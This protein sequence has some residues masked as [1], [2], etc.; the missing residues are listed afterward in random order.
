MQNEIKKAYRVLLLSAAQLPP[1][2]PPP[3]DEML[4]HHKV[5]H[6]RTNPGTQLY[7]W[8]NGDNLWLKERKVKT[9][10][11]LLPRFPD[12][13]SNGQL[14]VSNLQI[15]I[16]MSL[17]RTGGGS[18]AAYSGNEFCQHFSSCGSRSTITDSLLRESYLFLRIAQ[19]YHHL[20]THSF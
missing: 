9:R 17:V 1:P 4:A 13:K 14:L 3:L 15:T 11:G 12:M 19:L 16:A 5:K 18:L 20:H 10:Q 2:P 7:I 6:C 8:V